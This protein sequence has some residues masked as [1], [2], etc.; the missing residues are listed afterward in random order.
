V[1]TTRSLLKTWLDHTRRG[2]SRDPVSALR[3]PD[4]YTFAINSDAATYRYATIAVPDSSRLGLIAAMLVL[5]AQD[6]GPFTPQEVIVTAVRGS[7]VFIVT[8]PAAVK[9]KPPRAC[10]GV[11]D[12]VIAHVAGRNLPPSQDPADD[13]YRACYGERVPRYPAFQKILAQV[14]GIAANLPAR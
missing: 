14:Q 6:S 2:I 10:L 12:S 8:G 4:F 1:V 13:A 7:R 3:D 5:F 9:I 11:R